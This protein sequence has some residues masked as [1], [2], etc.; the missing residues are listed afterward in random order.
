CDV[1]APC[2]LGPV[3]TE[4]SLDTFKCSAI[5]GA[6]NNQLASPELGRA[7]ADAGILYAPDYIINAGGLI[8]VEDELHGY[9]SA[10]AHR[11]AEGIAETL[12]EVFSIADREGVTP[13]E[14]ADRIAEA[15]IRS[16]RG[17]AS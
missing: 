2:A 1:F 12:R 8:N 7:L 5:A 15:R 16:A 3:V 10:R 17:R 11:K 9:D 14:A 13:S 6:A 4:T